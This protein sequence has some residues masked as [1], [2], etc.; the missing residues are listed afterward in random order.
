MPGG[1][2]PVAAGPQPGG[3]RAERNPGRGALRGGG[4]RGA[5]APA[6]GGR[7]RGSP[8]LGRAGRPVRGGPGALEG[9]AGGGR[10]RPGGALPGGGQGGTRA[11]GLGEAAGSVTRRPPTV[12]A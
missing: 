10:W 11:G 6:A 9:P 5:P 7:G 2:T 3:A 4:A 12:A 1:A 8:S